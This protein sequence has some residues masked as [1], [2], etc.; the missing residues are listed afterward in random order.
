MC[1]NIFERK[2]GKYTEKRNSR[3]LVYAILFN[4]FIKVIEHGEFSTFVDHIKEL[5]SYIFSL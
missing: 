4:E 2:F 3:N 5:F 1:G